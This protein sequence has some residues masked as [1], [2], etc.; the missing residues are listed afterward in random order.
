MV[1]PVE[2]DEPL[3]LATAGHGYV[4]PSG[5]EL[6]GDGDRSGRMACAVTPVDDCN[7]RHSTI[8]LILTNE[9]A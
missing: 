7:G 1:E 9:G 8:E 3:A 5:L 4:D 6:L 2:F